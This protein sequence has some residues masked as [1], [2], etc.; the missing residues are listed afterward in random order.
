MFREKVLL[1]SILIGFSLG[2]Q[3]ATEQT[4][5]TSQPTPS[6]K[7]TATAASSKNQEKL[8]Q[9]EWYETEHDFGQITEG[10]KATYRFKFKNTGSHPLILKKVKP[11]C[12]CTTPDYSKDPVAPGEEG[13]IDVTYDSHGRP[14][15]F[16]KSVT[17][18]TNTEPRIHILRIKGEVLA[19]SK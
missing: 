9:I 1:I 10:E 8:T 15:Q 11:S 16:N 19:K 4:E 17:V 12:G 3:K 5:S 6:S 18:E 13:Y 7:Q 2:C 14:G